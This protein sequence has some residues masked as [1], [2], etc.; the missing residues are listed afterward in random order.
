MSLT[1]SD[2]IL[3][4]G[5]LNDNEL[6]DL[7]SEVVSRIKTNRAARSRSLRGS[8]SVGDRVEFTGRHGHVSG[9]ITKMK[10]K[11]ALVKQVNT[12][13]TWNVP[14]LMLESIA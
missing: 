8:F 7:N 3:S 2:I 14:I 11:Y 12:S 5:N 4:L 1:F 13:Q 6:V 10:R 9:T